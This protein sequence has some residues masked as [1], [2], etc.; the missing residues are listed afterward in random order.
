MKL[1][2]MLLSIQACEER[3]G[4]RRM[5]IIIKTDPIAANVGGIA[6]V[7]ERRSG[8]VR[9]DIGAR[10]FIWTSESSGGRGLLCRGDVARVSQEADRYVSI[11]VRV[12]SFPLRS[13]GNMQLAPVRDTAGDEPLVLLS[14]KLYKYSL[15]RVVQ[16]TPEEEAY[17]DTFF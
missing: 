4:A 12:E 2:K 9:L 17:L 6:Q 16:L 7:R 11:A 5:S 14:R 13:F 8:S 3:S 10:A 1:G 15:N